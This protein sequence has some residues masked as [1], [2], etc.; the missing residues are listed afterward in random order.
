ML[1]LLISFFIIIFSLFLFLRIL[2]PLLSIGIL[3][4]DLLDLF[5]NHYKFY[6]DI[7]MIIGFLQNVLIF[8]SLYR[9]N[10]DNMKVTEY[11]PDFDYDYG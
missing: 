3:D 6:R 7:F 1:I 4:V 5:I 8:C 9:T 2:K 10:D 11:S